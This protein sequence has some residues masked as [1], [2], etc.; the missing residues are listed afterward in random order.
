MLKLEFGNDILPILGGIMDEKEAR[1]FFENRL[2]QESNDKLKV[3]TNEKVLIKIANAIAAARPESIF[4]NTGTKEDLDWIKA[5]SLETGEE[6]SLTKD[7]HTIHYDLPQEQGRL[8]AKTFY[9]ADEDEEISSL[10]Q[11]ESRSKAEAHLKTHLCGIME[12]MTMMIG[13]YSRGPIGAKGSIPALEISSSTYVLH[14][15]NILYRN[16]Y[17]QFDAEIE[18][19]G[20]FLTN[21]HGQG[22]N[23]TE[24]LENAK[25]YMDRNWLTTYSLF[26][27]Y[28]GNTLLLKKGNHR[29]AVDLATYHHRGRELAEH[30]FVTG[31]TGPGG[32]KTYIAGAAPSGCGKTTTAMVGSDFIG[33]DLAQLWIGPDGSCRGINPEK[34]IFGIV[35][36]V[37][38]QGDP[39]LM[40]CLRDKDTEVIWS[41]VLVDDER[42]PRWT[43]DGD[44][45]PLAGKNHQGNWVAG[46]KTA[47]GKDVPISHPNARCTLDNTNLSNYNRIDGEDPAGVEVKII[48][49][50]G[51]DSDTLPPVWV[52]KNSDH[53]VVLGASIVSKATATEEGV[54]GVRRQPWANAPF[55]PGSLGDHMEAQFQFYNSPRFT[56]AGRPVM[57]GLNY[58][59]THESR[60]SSVKGLLG[61]KK[62]VKVWL[63]WLERYVHGDVAALE[64]PIGRIPLYED[65]EE[66]FDEI[67]K[68]Y[69]R[70]LYRMQFSL[71]IDN[72]VK[73]IDL[74]IDAYEKEANISYRLFSVYHEQKEELLRS[75]ER[76]GSVITPEQ[77]AYG[78]LVDS[79]KP[80]RNSKPGH[81]MAM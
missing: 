38:R 5:R 17:N 7:N 30:M 11:K 33:D 51:R 36:D 4:I 53:G 26:C 67:D 62:D 9:I 41:N 64:T 75:R 79:K 34:G 29:F 15:A 81:K 18:R 1:T 42:V 65:L 72:I 56:G 78:N 59:L 57:A 73:R 12:G 52:A 77:L 46:M 13:F 22:S 39:L 2:D 43:G 48:T 74:Q 68:P 50:S 80:R 71:Y 76:F 44:E 60:G 54:S 3:I 6:S 10:A 23:R 27:T 49:Y 24:D 19:Y 35:A 58:F 37:N 45:A 16:C 70:E 55:I 25:I 61:E 47:D 28:A 31:M 14:S 20:L 40:D 63:G 66:L 21:L 32:R 8:V 69:S